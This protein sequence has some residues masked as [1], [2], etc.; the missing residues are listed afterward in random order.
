MKDM[1]GNDICV[2]DHIVVIAH[3][4]RNSTLVSGVV[5][6]VKDTFAKYKVERL[7]GFKD[8]YGDPAVGDVKRVTQSHKVVDLDYD[9]PFE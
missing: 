7:G 5:L 8:F 2:D 6:E 4:R 9:R 1:F 3:T